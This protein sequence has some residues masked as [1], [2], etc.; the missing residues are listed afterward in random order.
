VHAAL[1][2]VLAGQPDRQVWHR[3]A[4]ALGPDEQVAA[5]LDD[6]AGRA[7][8][9][10]AGSAERCG[11]GAVAIFALE[12]AAQLSEEQASRGPAAARGVARA[13]FCH[14]GIAR[15]RQYGVDVPFMQLERVGR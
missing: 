8:R 4:A 2:E 6:A 1:A 11:A 13:N 15:T 9:G 5:A 10:G 3:A 7:G 14:P 12:R